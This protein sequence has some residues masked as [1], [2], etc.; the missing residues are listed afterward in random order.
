VEVL[1]NT[2]NWQYG[3]IGVTREA[4]QKKPH[5]PG[6]G[7]W[8]NGFLWVLLRRYNL[9]NYALLVVILPFWSGMSRGKMN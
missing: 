9:K 5:N 3:Y 4:T 7:E 2:Y 8:G 1:S 6:G